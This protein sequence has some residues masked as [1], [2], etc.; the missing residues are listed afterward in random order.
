MR[1]T[2]TVF[3]DYLTCKLKAFLTLKGESGTR[4]EYMTVLDEV[5][6]G[7]RALAAAALLNKLNLEPAAVEG[8]SIGAGSPLILDCRIVHDPFEFHFDALRRVKGKSDLGGFHYEPILFL[9][10]RTIAEDRKRLLAFGGF[11]LEK[12]Q[13][14]S[15]TSGGIVYGKECAITNVRLASWLDRSQDAIT[16]LLKMQ[17]PVLSLIKHC[18]IC[19][20]RDHCRREALEKDDLS[21]LRGI[22]PKE[23]AV[24]AAKGI[25]SVNQLS[26]TFRVRRRPRKLRDRP[27]L[28][29][30]ALRAL[31]LRE[32]KVY[33][34]T[35]PTI[36]DATTRVYLDME[37]DLN[38]RSIYLIGALVVANGVPAFHS[39]WADQPSEE[40][41]LFDNLRDLLAGLDNAHV[42]HFGSYESTALKRM[43][44][45]GRKKAFT[46]LLKER[47]T[48][49]LKAVYGNVYFP[50]YS[51]GLKD[52]GHFLGCQ[53]TEPD[54]SGIQSRVAQT[55]GAIERH[56][57]QG[58]TSSI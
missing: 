40:E 28:Y 22:K 20:F 32:K 44:S 27:N 15:P 47:S 3:R 56:R 4:H 10:E 23:I 1:I 46:N 57:P 19:Q 12:A 55:L 54:A 42:F 30:H 25:F 43:C 53:W 37:G 34:L 11:V 33:I 58:K 45:E 13:G 7:Y 38:A 50:T 24:F 26:Y 8:A 18:D 6:Q 36:P 9:T 39:F 14:V 5:Q 31:A 49:I 16:D 52:I 2:D 48:D 29:Y 51:N 41:V 35:R 17:R 21:L